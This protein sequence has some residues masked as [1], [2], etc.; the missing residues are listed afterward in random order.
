LRRPDRA[1]SCLLLAPVLVFAA[2]CGDPSQ[3]TSVDMDDAAVLE[4]VDA[5][6]FTGFSTPAAFVDPLA[7]GDFAGGLVGWDSDPALSWMLTPSSA[8]PPNGMLSATNTATGPGTYSLSQLV[9]LESACELSLDWGDRF[10][11]E[12]NQVPFPIGPSASVQVWDQDGNWLANLWGSTGGPVQSYDSQWETHTADI[13]AFAG[14]TVRISFSQMFPPPFP[15]APPLAGS[16]KFEVDDIAIRGV[17]GGAAPTAEFVPVPGKSLK[18]NK[19]VFTVQFSCGSG[20]GGDT[21]G[22]EATATL[23]GVPVEN[24]QVVELQLKSNKSKS[25]KAK[26]G[27]MLKMKGPSFELVVE[28]GGETITVSPVFAD[29]KGKSTKSK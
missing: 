6:V 29:A 28:C 7:N 17:S 8:P 18:A 22:S 14:S 23:N 20:C 3:I 9:T 2:A 16:S 4:H 10:S 1:T 12:L 25:V 19:G 26:S 27:K 5:R 15:G 24:G 13:T 21:G 11:W